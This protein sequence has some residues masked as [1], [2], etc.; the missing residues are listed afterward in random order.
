[1]SSIDRAELHCQIDE[2]CDVLSGSPDVL[3]DLPSS[4]VEPESLTMPERKQVR[5]ARAAL[6]PL[7]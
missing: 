4:A 1:M 3:G 5:L 2:L 7:L 6:G